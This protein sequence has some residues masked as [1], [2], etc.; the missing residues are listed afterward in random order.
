MTE[1]GART[2]Q[3]AHSQLTGKILEFLPEGSGNRLFTQK[4]GSRD[5]SPP[6]VPGL[7]AEQ[8]K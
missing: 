7:R 4:A 8:N 6:S 1:L 3:S 2:R 5:F